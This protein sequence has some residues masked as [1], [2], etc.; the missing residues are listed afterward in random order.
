M[1]TVSNQNSAGYT[2]SPKVAHT[3]TYYEEGRFHE[4]SDVVIRRLVRKLHLNILD[5]VTV[6]GAA[7]TTGPAPELF[8]SMIIPT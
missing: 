3:V 1:E 6:T 5:G 4:R 7:G 2:A 8:D